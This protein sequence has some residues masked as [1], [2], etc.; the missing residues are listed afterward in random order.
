MS[1]LSNIKNP[2]NIKK[3]DFLPIITSGN[4]L[5]ISVNGYT[6]EE[7]KNKYPGFDQCIPKI[8]YNNPTNPRELIID[9]TYINY[10]GPDDII[11]NNNVTD[12]IPSPFS[13]NNRVLSLNNPNL[14]KLRTHFKYNSIKFINMFLCENYIILGDE[15]E[16]EDFT[17]ESSGPKPINIVDP[18]YLKNC[19]LNGNATIVFHKSE[20]DTLR[21]VSEG[22]TTIPDYLDYLKS[23]LKNITFGGEFSGIQVPRI[24]FKNIK[25]G[26]KWWSLVNNMNYPK[27]PYK[28]III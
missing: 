25:R 3:I 4:Y 17:F 9:Q 6:L 18:K 11:G 23:K 21:M 22:D 1:L 10:N 2:E 15:G 7:L 5:D 8:I 24:I 27:I 19:T 20:Y 28:F 16:V 13:E 12:K 14:N 26:S